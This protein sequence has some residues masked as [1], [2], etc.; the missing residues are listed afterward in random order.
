MVETLPDFIKRRLAELETASEPLRVEFSRI[1]EALAEID[2]ERSQLRRALD[3]VSKEE[4][5]QT[6]LFAPE[7]AAYYGRRPSQ[8]TMKGTVLDIL[9]EYPEGETAIDILAQVN[10]RLGTT[11]LRTSLSP[12]LSRLKADGLI[13]LEGNIWK[14][15]PANS[16][17][18]ET[19]K[20]AIL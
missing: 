1:Q 14:L 3:A 18:A 10:N 13:V 5:Q 12:Q 9:A 11:Y 16:G 6:A 7:M 2:K 20:G 15:A 8:K 17:D 4:A 19:D